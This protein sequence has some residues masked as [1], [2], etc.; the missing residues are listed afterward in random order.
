M[1]LHWS[2]RVA[3][4]VAVAV[5]MAAMPA[6]AQ[7]PLTLDE[8]IARGL[9]Q[10]PRLAEARARIDAAEA[11]VA[12]RQAQSGPMMSASSGY[13]RTNHVDEFGI[14]QPDGSLRVL[15]PD[16]PSN[17][18]VRAEFGMP[19]YTSGRVQS[20]VGAARGD[21][22]AS[23]ADERTLRADIELEVATAY[24]TLVTSRARTAVLERALARADQFVADVGARVDAGILPPNDRL[25]AQAQRA[26]QRVQLIQAQNDAA[27]AEAVLARLIGAASGERFEPVTPVTL[28]SPQAQA[29]AGREATAVSREA[30]AARSERQAITLRVQALRDAAHALSAATRPQVGLVAAIEPARPNAR[31]VPRVNQWNTSWDL[32]V[33]VTW[34]LWDG[35]RSRADQAVIHAQAAALSSRVADLD[36]AV[37][38]E[39][40]QRQLEMRSAR[41]ALEAVAEAVAAATEAR[42][43]IG[44]RFAAG[45]AVG[46]DVLDSDVALLEAELERTRLEAS[47]RVA[48]ARLLR[49]LGGRP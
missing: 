42:R 35:G 31:F 22:D 24:W 49:A 20:A 16:I 10:A 9:A 3:S 45:V 28:A 21:A 12:A 30:S 25:T 41:A 5:L 17:Y 19:L 40:Q 48:E 18:R 34:T 23:R 14:P 29:A 37:A 13:L 27:L 11:G 39:I 36:S 2:W 6:K 44:E 47:E 43:V 38:L 4:S 26:R 46:T 32:G 7:T 8:A 33:N 15:F 1:S